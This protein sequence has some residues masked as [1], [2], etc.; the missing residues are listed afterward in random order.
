MRVTELSVSNSEFQT[1][2]GMGRIGII[3]KTNKEGFKVNL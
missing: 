1:R 3:L 2:A